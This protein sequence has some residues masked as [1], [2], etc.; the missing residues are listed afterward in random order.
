MVQ[1][2]AD[3]RC[4]A[5]LAAAVSCQP[6]A[7]PLLIIGPPWCFSKWEQ[8]SWLFEVQANPLYRWAAEFGGVTVKGGAMM[9]G[10]TYQ[11]YSDPDDQ[12][13]PV[14]SPT[15]GHSTALATQASRS[16]ESLSGMSSASARAL[17]LSHTSP[18]T[19][20]HN[21]IG[22]AD[23]QLPRLHLALAGLL[24]PLQRRRLQRHQMLDLR[25]DRRPLLRP[26]GCRGLWCL[27]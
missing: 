3:R 20:P 19:M 8:V 10:G 1:H 26:G 6:P 17:P 22:P 25:P 14:C 21:C 16:A 12:Q 13:Y 11:C 15:R 24:L 23:R 18:P 27:F 9:S 4:T 2:I 7:Q 5:A